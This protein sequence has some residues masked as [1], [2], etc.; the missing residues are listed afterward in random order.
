M[1]KKS[2]PWVKWFPE[3]FLHGIS[4][5]ETA[6]E[7]AVYT[8]VLNLIYDKQGPWP[9]SPKKLGARCKL[10]V[11][12]VE[13]VVD[14]LV[15]EGK[16]LLIDGC[17]TNEKAQ[18]VIGERQGLSEKASA[19]AHSRWQ[20]EEGKDKKNKDRED[21]D[22]SGSHDKKDAIEEGRG[23]RESKKKAT[24]KKAPPAPPLD[25]DG[26]P[27]VSEAR[28]AFDLYNEVADRVGGR[29]ADDLTDSRRTKLN[30]RLNGR[31]FVVWKEAMDMVEKSLFLCGEVPPK[32]G[33]KPFQLHLDMLLRPD[34]FQRL[35]EGFYGE[36]REPSDPDE[37][38]DAQGWS[39]TRWSRVMEIWDKTG[40]WPDDAG[41]E[42]GQPGCRAPMTG[43]DYDR[44]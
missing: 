37:P 31:G 9:Y 39:K 14:G 2:T 22:A 33:E 41:P 28:K 30:A 16:L 18:E 4:D 6:Y 40:S 27:D 5:L 35:R 11:S 8:V 1:P 21:A 44:Q 7:I 29:R 25:L 19:A 36:D 23:K 20:D 24:P 15:A 32:R 3:K 12:V 26:G 42:P 17:L 38:L 10:R 34:N 43:D 13:D